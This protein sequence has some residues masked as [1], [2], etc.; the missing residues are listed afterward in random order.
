MSVI[1]HSCIFFVFIV[2]NYFNQQCGVPPLIVQ[3]ICEIERRGLDTAGLYTVSG[4]SEEVNN[5]RDKFCNGVPNLNGIDIHVLCSCLKDLICMQKNCLIPE[6]DFSKLADALK[7]KNDVSKSLCR[8][9]L[10]LPTTNR[11]TLA[12]LILHLQKYILNN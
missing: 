8:G 1:Y 3:C 6:S 7:T 11:N 4:S 2:L 9:V 10:E 5:L 12:F